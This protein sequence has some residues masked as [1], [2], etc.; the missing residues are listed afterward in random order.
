VAALGFLRTSQIGFVWWGIAIIV[1]L[2][3]RI[4]ID[5]TFAHRG[6]GSKPALWLERFL[7]GSWFNG[8][9]CGVG[10][11][12]ALLYSDAFTQIL[13]ITKMNA[14]V[15]GTAARNSAHPRAVIGSI[16][17]AGLP[18]VLACLARRD[19][20]YIGFTPFIVLFCISALSA[21]RHLYAQSVRFFVTDEEKAVLVGEI[22]RSNHELALANSKFATTNDQLAAANQKLAASAA[23]DGLTGVPNRRSFD[24]AFELE[25][26]SA[27][28]EG[29]DLS[30]LIFDIDFFKGYNDQYGH[31][32]GD[33]CLR[34]VASALA[35]GLHRP[36][37]LFA[38]YGGEEFVALLPQ[39]NLA[40]ALVVAED[41][42][43]AVERLG[44]ENSSSLIGR[45]TVSVG[46][47]ILSADADAPVTELLGRA[48]Q[49]LY[50]AK[51]SGRNSVRVDAYERPP[52]ALPTIA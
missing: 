21:S 6:A 52:S 34:R 4:T 3:V 44:L 20:F 47:A 22:T 14:F 11:A 9:L 25:T 38:R 1:C 15:M 36:G 40:G 45:V 12:G 28:R 48:D 26:R 19:L 7:V 31:L 5:E 35:A 39:T 41:L 16:W 2:V 32:A 37:D 17:L 13:M 23:T 10:G 27:R 29:S 33:D 50:L 42:R 46:A 51:H 24:D 30:L 8:L 43:R 49:A 18:I